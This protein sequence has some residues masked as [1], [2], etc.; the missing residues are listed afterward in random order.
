MRYRPNPAPLKNGLISVIAAQASRLKPINAH[1]GV[2]LPINSQVARRDSD[3]HS[4]GTNM[5]NKATPASCNI[6]SKCQHVHVNSVAW[7]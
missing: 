7:P 6:V 2:S 4:T 5:K 3:N 1:A